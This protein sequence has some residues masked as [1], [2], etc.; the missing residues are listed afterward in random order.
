M[1]RI[2]VIGALPIEDTGS[3]RGQENKS[4]PHS[5]LQTWLG[6]QT[7]ESELGRQLHLQKT[8]GHCQCQCCSE[9]VR[10][11]ELLTPKAEFT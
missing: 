10:C 5:K 11:E 7:R 2:S 3:H 8:L 4:R 1:G 9:L 6:A